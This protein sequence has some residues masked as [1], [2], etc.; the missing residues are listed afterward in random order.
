MC[1]AAIALGQDP[2]FPCVLWSN[3]D[4]FFSRAAQPMQWWTPQAE[5]PQILSGR[6]LS[7]GGTWLGLNE[8]GSLALLTNVREPAKTFP[9]S[10][11]RGE[12]VPTWLTLQGEK[13][14]LTS[15]AAEHRRGF[16]F[17]AVELAALQSALPANLTAKFLS[18]RTEPQ[19]T[20]LHAGVH[21]VSN[22]ALNTPW[23]KLVA[24]KQKLRRALAS[25]DSVHSIMSD[26]FAA[27]ADR[28]AAPAHELPNTGLTYEREV[29]LSSAF[30]HI[31]GTTPEQDYGTRC[32]TIVVVEEHGAE[33]IVHVVERSFD[34]DAKPAGEVR[35]AHFLPSPHV[36]L[37]SA[38]S[39]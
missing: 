29:Q 9:V 20:S 1:L 18:N 2:R 10:P 38:R 31:V 28:S 13:S 24:I 27:L 8:R 22:A 39:W 5:A 36:E 14:A 35:F 15:W 23:P 4:E 32:S 30:I 11:S 26:G 25:A 6:D 21:G 3:R 37:S 17:L 7:A 33:R 16:N 12:I 34:R 19:M